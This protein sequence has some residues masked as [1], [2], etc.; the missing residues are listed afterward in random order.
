MWIKCKF[1]RFFR[2]LFHLCRK[3]NVTHLFFFVDSG[4][5]IGLPD[6]FLTVP[7]HCIGKPEEY[8]NP[9]KDENTCNN[10]ELIPKSL[11]GGVLQVRIRL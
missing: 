7:P 5:A 8:R 3:K 11:G 2:S 6:E 9:Q 4:K 1:R 10:T